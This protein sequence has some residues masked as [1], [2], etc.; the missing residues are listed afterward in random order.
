MSV[1]HNVSFYDLLQYPLFKMS[2]K[3]DDKELM[4]KIFWE[5]GIDTTQEFELHECN[6]RPV[7]S[8]QPWYGLRVEGFERLDQEWLLS[9]A[10][11]FEAKTYTKDAS[12]RL[13]LLR[14]D[15]RNSV[16]KKKSVDEDVECSVEVFDAGDDCI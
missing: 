2:A 5:A 8:K 11:S 16:H 14:L 10:A 9:G 1:Y 4:K 13:D 15:P 7:T 6:H 12:L 3:Q